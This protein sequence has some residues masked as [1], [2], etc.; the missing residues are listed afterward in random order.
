MYFLRQLT[1]CIFDIGVKSFIWCWMQRLIN[2]C[3]GS[4]EAHLRLCSP[5]LWRMEPTWW[6]HEAC[7]EEEEEEVF[8]VWRCITWTLR[9]EMAACW[10]HLWSITLTDVGSMFSF[11]CFMC[12]FYYSW[13]VGKLYLISV[14]SKQ[15]L[16]Y[17]VYIFECLVYFGINY[18]LHLFL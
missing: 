6:R 8:T 17:T 3:G 5:G 18:K 16:L 14:H 15:A 13:C 7:R 1:T 10:P 2:L 12:F 11:L 4:P 9:A